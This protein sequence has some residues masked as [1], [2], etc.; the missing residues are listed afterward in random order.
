M[1]TIWLHN[2]TGDNTD[3]N[4]YDEGG[5]GGGGDDELK[6]EEEEEENWHTLPGLMCHFASCNWI[7]ISMVWRKTTVSPVR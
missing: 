5:G 1:K 4:N 3:D 7:Y 6:E 2:D